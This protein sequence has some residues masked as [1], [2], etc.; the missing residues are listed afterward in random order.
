MF[1]LRLALVSAVVMF[2]LEYT[3]LIRLFKRTKELE[4]TSLMV[5]PMM[6]I[7]AQYLSHILQTNTKLFVKDRIDYVSLFISFALIELPFS[8][9]GYKITP[10]AGIPERVVVAS[11]F[12][13]V[14]TLIGQSILQK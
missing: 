2:I 14:A 10:D 12:G 5:A 9:K 3:V 11:S 4:T 7:A 6:I 8:L 13:V 1:D